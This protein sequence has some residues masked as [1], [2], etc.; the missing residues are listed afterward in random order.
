M[1]AIRGGKST[2]K[3]KTPPAGM[4]K[5]MT[6]S[7]VAEDVEYA[8]VLLGF[9]QPFMSDVPEMEELEETLNIGLVAWNMAVI[10]QNDEDFYKGYSKNFLA[11]INLPRKSLQLLEKMIQSKAAMYADYNVILM[12]CEMAPNK[13]GEVVINVSPKTYE[14]FVKELLEENQGEEQEEQLN[15][16][17]FAVVPKQPFL[18]W[19][20]KTFSPGKLPGRLLEENSMYLVDPLEDKKGLE[21]WLKKN[22][23]DVF[24]NELNEWTEDQYEWP[25]NR[26]YKMFC[27]WFEVKICSMIYDLGTSPLI[28]D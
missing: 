5:K 22:Y 1:K 3:S 11:E 9:V 6:D 15:R 23:D 13:K 8:Q 12:D 4:V 14:Q 17:S 25:K 27:D 16:S 7:R 19:V 21:K 10:K 2:G 28:K 26:T 20:E 18:D 24:V